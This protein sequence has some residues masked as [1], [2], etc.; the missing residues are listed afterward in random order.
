MKIRAILLEQGTNMNF[1]SLISLKM[2]G[3]ENE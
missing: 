1:N 2:Q 3:R